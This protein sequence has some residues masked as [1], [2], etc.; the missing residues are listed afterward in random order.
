MK[1]KLRRFRVAFVVNDESQVD[2][3]AFD[4]DHAIEI[5][6]A[7]EFDGLILKSAVWEVLDIHELRDKDRFEPINSPDLLSPSSN[8]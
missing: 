5:A 3:W 2:L 1:H 4:A 6:V 8:D 7:A